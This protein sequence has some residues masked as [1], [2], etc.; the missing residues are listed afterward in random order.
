MAL[1]TYETKFLL[2]CPFAEYEHAYHVPTVAVDLFDQPILVYGKHEQNLEFKDL[3]DFTRK[4][5]AGWAGGAVETPRGLSAPGT[6]VPFASDF[7]TT[8]TVNSTASPMSGNTVIV[9]DDGND[10]A[11]LGTSELLSGSINETADNLEYAISARSRVITPVPE[12]TPFRFYYTTFHVPITSGLTWERVARW[13]YSDNAFGDGSF[14]VTV[15]PTLDTLGPDE[16]GP[17]VEGDIYSLHLIV[18][19]GTLGQFP[20]TPHGGTITATVLGLTSSNESEWGDIW[21]THD[22]DEY[23]IA[24][25]TTL[26]WPPG[27]MVV[28]GTYYNDARW[29]ASAELFRARVG[30]ALTWSLPLFYWL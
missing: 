30:E 29:S 4:D 7:V 5:P 9:D 19:V 3:Y 28:S 22:G 10:I 14:S 20:E 25:I 1:P 13:G 24:I 16:G 27:D 18:S 6:V 12:T 17:I 26:P 8:H 23:S 11:I 2:R 15:S 21:E